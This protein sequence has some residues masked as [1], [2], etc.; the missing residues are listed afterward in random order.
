MRKALFAVACIGSAY[1][2]SPAPLAGIARVNKAPVC[3]RPL[4]L[5]MQNNDDVEYKPLIPTP[6]KPLPPDYKN[7][8][9]LFER[10][11]FVE[12]ANT[13]TPKV[14]NAAMAGGE[15]FGGLTRREAYAFG[16][17]I[18]VGL[19]GVL[20]AVTRN[21][22]YDKNDASR[23]AGKVEVNA[24]AISTPEI[25]ANLKDLRSN[26]DKLFELSKQFKSDKNAQLSEQVKAFNIV[27]LRDDLNKLGLAAFDEDTQ[28]KTDRLSRNIIQDLV[29]LETALRLKE[30]VERSPKR[31]AA[32]DKW[33]KQSLAD[34]EKFLAYFP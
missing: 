26:R 21:P 11:G 18:S 25:Q 1:A 12:S 33:F 15:G 17:A 2:F 3:H 29:E 7:E 30:G 4:S 8:P 6:D 14:Y 16:G 19:L 24:Q 23:D 32:S 5:R 31:V 27:K 13:P 22:G 9:T 28:I 20:F 34:F 10:Q